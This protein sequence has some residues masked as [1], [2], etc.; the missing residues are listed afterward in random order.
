M[1]Y[2]INLSTAIS[3]GQPRSLGAE[4]T[5]DGVHFCLHSR[6]ATK[7]TLHLFNREEDLQ[8]AMSIALEPP[9][10]RSGDRW[11]VH[12]YGCRAGQLYLY[13]AEGPNQPEQG[14]RFDP[15]KFLQDPYAKAVCRNNPSTHPKPP[16]QEEASNIHTQAKCVIVDDYFDW[17]GDRPLNYPLADCIIYEAHVKGMTQNYP[18]K[19]PGTY[20]GVIEHIPY[21]QRLGISSLELLPVMDFSPYDYSERYNPQTGQPLSNYW[22]YNTRNFFAPAAHYAT[23]GGMAAVYEFKQMV[24]ALHAAGIEVIL[25]VVFNHSGESDENGETLSFRGLD[26]PAYYILQKDPRFYTNYTGCGNV[27]NCNHPIMRELIIDCLRYWVDE[28]H[29]DGFRFDLASIFRRDGRGQVIAA[30]HSL[31]EALSQDSVLANTKL[32]AEPW[33]ASGAYLLGD[34][35]QTSRGQSRWA[36]WN[37]KYRDHIRQFW[38]GG[39]GI[40]ELASGLAGSANIFYRPQQ[41]PYHSINF[42]CCHDGQTMRDLCS[43]TQKHNLPNGE[44]NRDGHNHN[45]SH[46][47]G[48]EGM[49]DPAESPQNQQLTRVRCQMVKNYLVTLLLSTGTPMLLAGDE[50]G[51]SQYGNNNAYCQDNGV[52]WLPPPAAGEVL[53]ELLKQ[54]PELPAYSDLYRFT[55]QL[56]ALRRKFKILHRREFLQNKDVCWYGTAACTEPNAKCNTI[57]YPLRQQEEWHRSHSCLGVLLDGGAY[58]EQPSPCFFW[59]LNGGQEPLHFYLPKVPNG[60]V[61]SG[62]SSAHNIPGLP[63]LPTPQERP[64]EQPQWQLLINTA[65]AAPEDICLPFGPFAYPS[66]SDAQNVQEVRAPNPKSQRKS[67][68]VVVAPRSV[69]VW[70]T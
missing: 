32:I 52:S 54:D 12:V 17:Q 57:F 25:D 24:K 40:S 64:Q 61:P 13:T 15:S 33:D 47:Y 5:K 29:V 46:N 18:Y 14:L 7:V 38:Y 56:I 21:L 37:D 19:H 67:K 9:Y 20:L 45:F 6:D 49:V 4:L 65:L 41:R 34:F 27:L 63:G 51:N 31:V 35:G 11:H 42:I 36:E 23:A 48:W 50:L 59:V 43:Y 62:R 28:M 1:N 66:D 26:N 69:V 60:R 39:R 22:G 44:E 70:S 68:L 55:A 3:P 8:P 2:S 30:E 58:I 10:H 16:P 53:P